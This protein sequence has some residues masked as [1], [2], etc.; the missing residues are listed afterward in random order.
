MLISR[1]EERLKRYRRYV[2]EARA[3]NYPQRA[4]DRVIDSDMVE[5]ERKKN[6][7][8]NR[9]RRFRYRT[10]YFTDS[11]IIGTKDFVSGNYQRFKDLFMSK[12]E[13]VP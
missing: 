11:G 1:I 5:Y 9:M 8:F 10:R 7:E 3:V 12:R 2:Y 6:F 4:A 13:K